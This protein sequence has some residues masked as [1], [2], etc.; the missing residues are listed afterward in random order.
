MPEQ[1]NRI[2]YNA[3]SDKIVGEY[4][5]DI[6]SDP[7]F[8]C[9]NV[10]TC[11]ASS[12]FYG[13]KKDI[14][15]ICK[16]IKLANICENDIQQCVVLAKNNLTKEKGTVLTSFVNIIVPIKNAKDDFGNQKF[17]RLPPLGGS[18]KNNSNEICNECA[19]INR[20][21]K[22]PGNK[23][24]DFTSPGQN[25]CE[26]SD[27]FEYYYYPLNIENINRKLK[28]APELYLGNYKVINTNIIYANNQDDLEPAKLYDILIEDGINKDLAYNFITQV[29]YSNRIERTNQLN[30][31][32]KSISEKTYNS[33]KN[34]SFYE[35]IVTFYVIFITFIIL[36]LFNLMN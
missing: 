32:L 17:L 16:D 26:Y 33:K 21:A 12:T 3:G 18:K 7:T 27:D 24:T 15:K 4:I 10:E 29:L 9:N 2:F 20:F 28:N 13:N 6:C 36:L 5:D 25:E 22:A 31:H 19:C 14:D 35:T 34:T 8:L 30:L 23:D 1:P 11:S